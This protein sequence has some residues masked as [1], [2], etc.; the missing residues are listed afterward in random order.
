MSIELARSATVEPVVRSRVPAYITREPPCRVRREE[1]E[2]EMVV[3]QA[4]GHRQRLGGARCM[5]IK[6]ALAAVIAEGSAAFATSVA[7]EGAATVCGG[8]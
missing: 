5:H 6:V 4:V 2:V 3:V 1:L 8:L 7:V